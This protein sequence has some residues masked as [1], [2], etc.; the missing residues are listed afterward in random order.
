MKQF[1]IG[2]A[3]ISSAVVIVLL[4]YSLY[5][6]SAELLKFKRE[7]LGAR[8]DYRNLLDRYDDYVEQTKNLRQLVILA[9][10]PDSKNIQI[11]DKINDYSKKINGDLSIYYK[12][13][14]TEETVFIDPDKTYYMASLYKVILT[15]FL[16]DEVAN[17]NTSLKTR[18]GSGSATLNT[19]LEKIITESNNE[20]AEE[21]ADEYGWE[22]IQTNMKEK[23][24]IEFNFNT[25]L[26]TSVRSI[27][28][29]FEDIA[30]SLKIP[31][32]E[33]SYI[34]DLLKDQK[35]TSK[36]PKY[37]PSTIYSHNKT[38]EFDGFSHDAGIF[39]TPKA[40]YIL[41]FMSK[42]KLPAETNEQ[43]A[44]MSKEI[45]QSLNEINAQ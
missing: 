11:A 22:N 17:G 25:D 31:Q 41:V 7:T 20:Y 4:A 10:T 44:L 33:S 8:T 6:N 43:M 14:T 21:L 35:K 30:L 19:A 37:L 34:L 1:L 24:G 5:E 23:L 39:Y 15:L 12:N 13:L 27:G 40:N 18:V 36:L 16:L 38:G 2:L 29:L 3:A 26:E 45:Y 42:T 28:L 9:K 32:S